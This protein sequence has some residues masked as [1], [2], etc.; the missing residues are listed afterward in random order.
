MINELVQPNTVIASHANEEATRNGEV[1]PGT[2]TAAFIEAT[3]VPVYVPLSGLTMA[4]DGDGRC[5]E[6]CS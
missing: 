4:F 2:R 6:G 5:V 1:L 3:A